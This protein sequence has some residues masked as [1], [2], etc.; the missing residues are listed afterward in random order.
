MAGASSER[1]LSGVDWKFAGEASGDEAGHTVAG[2]GDVNGDGLGDLLVAAN[3]GAGGTDG[4]VYV[5]FWR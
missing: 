2:A 1:S 5:V 3:G 4:V